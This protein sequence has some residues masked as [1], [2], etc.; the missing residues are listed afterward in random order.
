[1]TPTANSLTLSTDEDTPLSV[2]LSG[3]DPDGDPLT[4][5]ILDL[6]SEGTL[7][8]TAPDFTYTPA[9]NFFGPDTFTYVVNDGTDDS[10]RLR[11][12]HRSLRQ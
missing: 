10:A 11:F 7:S 5:S 9:D 8:G 1:M 6:P 4:Y 3:T 12:P 2:L